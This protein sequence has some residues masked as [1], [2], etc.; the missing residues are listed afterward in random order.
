[1]TESSLP[2]STI[3]RV[4]A[5]RYAVALERFFSDLPSVERKQRVEAV[6]DQEKH[7]GT[8]YLY[9]VN[10][11]RQIAAAALA[12]AQ[13]GR[14]AVVWAPRLFEEAVDPSVTAQLMDALQ[15]DLQSTGVRIAQAL[16]ESDENTQGDALQRAGFDRVGDLLYMISLLQQIRFVSPDEMPPPETE[17]EFAPYT[18]ENAE[19]LEQIVEATYRETLDCPQLDGV[20]DI[21]DVLEGYRANG[22]FDPQR[23]FIVRLANQDVGCLLLSDYPDTGHWELVYM[24]LIPEVR[25]Q[26]LG[27]E[28]VLHAQR[29]AREAGRDRLILAVDAENKPAVDMYVNAG[30]EVWDR[31]H[32]FLKIYDQ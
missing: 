32:V 31:R 17:L 10:L 16:L 6:L 28:V 18:P 26:R 30:F 1:M 8:I 3:K 9:E 20:R 12:V 22:E 24:G 4:L 27:I 15:A 13:E 23:W 25:G 21:N 29:L 11:E 5:V 14:T 7:G 19:R 2:P